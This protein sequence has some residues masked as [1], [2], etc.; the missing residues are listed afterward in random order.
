[1]RVAFVV[2]NQFQLI[3]FENL[4]ER[5]P[6]S[7]VLIMDRGENMRYFDR[8][9]AR[10]RNFKII[11]QR[12]FA[13]LD[14]AYDIIFFQSPFPAMQSF[15][16]TKLVSLQYGL[17]KEKHNYGEWRSLADMNLM[18][19]DYSAKRVSHFSP[20]FPVGNPKF[21]FWGDFSMPSHRECRRREM[22][23]NRHKK[24]ILYMPT[25][26]TLGST[27]DLIDNFDTISSE[28]N[29]ILKLHH[30]DDYKFD[31]WSARAKNI[32]FCQVYS[33][34]FDQLKL[35]SVA[36]L[37]ISDFS[38]AIFDAVFS[39]VPV[40]LYQGNVEKKVGEQKFDRTSLEY[41][42][43]HE[44]G[45]VFEN[46]AELGDAV[47]RALIDRTTLINQASKLRINLFTNE[48]DGSGCI[49][50]I[51]TRIDDLGAGRIPPLTPEQ[52]C[53]RESIKELRN[54]KAAEKNR[55]NRSWR[56][57]WL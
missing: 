22:G 56:L 51:M 8:S 25:W 15:K 35:L 40:L 52:Q 31:L 5:I 36:D 39:K 16:I 45:A 20:S 23:L 19:G 32:G 46:A 18:Y 47:Y 9:L 21:E 43:R 17:A 14:G 33:G 10:K 28:Y 54:L 11:K 29:L 27:E 48:F 2:W 1:M 4:I 13:T 41:L 42:R 24:T 12:A 57:P 37:V 7:M 3:Q 38:G 34:A 49:K 26:G 53:V 6:G 30:N 44:I 55:R 50:N